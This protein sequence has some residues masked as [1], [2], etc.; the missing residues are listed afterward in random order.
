M[1]KR[2]IDELLLFWKHKAYKTPLIIEGARQIGKTYSITNFGKTHYQ[3]FINI[4]FI[5]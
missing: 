1:L 2:K 3:N 4:N 5:I